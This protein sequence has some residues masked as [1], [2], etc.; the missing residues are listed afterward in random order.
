MVKKKEEAHDGSVDEKIKKT[1]KHLEDAE[2]RFQ[3]LIEK[4]DELHEEG[5][6]IHLSHQ[7]G[8]GI[9]GIL[10]AGTMGAMQ[11]IRDEAYQCLVKRVVE[12]SVFKVRYY[13]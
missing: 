7:W 3:A 12:Q 13:K 4:R 2:K 5:L 10:A 1:R 8:A 11:L 9:S 6:E